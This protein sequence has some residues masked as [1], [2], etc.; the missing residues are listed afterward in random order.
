MEA[1]LNVLRRFNACVTTCPQ[2]MELISADELVA[3][4]NSVRERVLTAHSARPGGSPAPILVAVSKT[5]PSELLKAAYDAGQRDFG[6]NYVQ[7]VVAKGLELPSD[8]RWHFIG[9]LQTNK[10]KELV[11]VPN[12]FCVHTVDTIKL[13]SELQKRVA[14][15]RPDRPLEI[16]VQVWPPRTRRAP[17]ALAGAH[18]F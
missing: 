16:M 4:L 18:I 9:H 1:R 10:V 17:S 13:A 11:S 6:E 7:E 12:L 15:L 14:A 2:E 3:N 8:L 5:K